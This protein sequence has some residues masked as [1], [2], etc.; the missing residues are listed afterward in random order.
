MNLLINKS[1]NN[2]Y[3]YIFFSLLG[4]LLI[5]IINF[6]SIKGITSD[7]VIQFQRI[8]WQLDSLIGFFSNNNLTSNRGDF[9][10]YIQK[11]PS[12]FYYKLVNPTDNIAGN[13]T[14][15]KASHVSIYVYTI[16]T[17][18]ILLFVSQKCKLKNFWLAPCFLLISPVF[19]GH[20]IFNIKDIPFAFFYTLF[21]LLLLLYFESNLENEKRRKYYLIIICSLLSSFKLTVLPIFIFQ[22]M[23]IQFLKDYKEN[24]P[25]EIPN[26]INSFLKISFQCCLIIIIMT[27]HAWINPFSYI[28]L[29]IYR[30]INYP[31]E[32]CS[33]FAG[34]CSSKYSLNG[35]RDFINI[36]Y[37]F[38]WFSI[39]FTILNIFQFLGSFFLFFRTCYCIFFQ[40]KISKKAIACFVFGLQLFLI[41]FIGIITNQGTYNGVRHFLF[42][43]PPNAFLGS[44]A[45]HY[46]ER[47]INYI[48]LK[49]VIG[50]FLIILLVIN[51]IDILSLSPYQY[52]YL[53]EL[54]RTKHLK[55]NTDLDYWG[56][57]LSKL[58]EKSKVKFNLDQDEE[59]IF[60]GY[61]YIRRF[62]LGSINNDYD[63]FWSYKQPLKVIKRIED[64]Y[65]IH[66]ECQYIKVERYYPIT[67]HKAELSFIYS[68]KKNKF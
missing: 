47:K 13:S 43:F 52:T 26:L 28:P 61:D 54:S 67:K 14:Y 49:K 44:Y 58:Y 5:S 63:I 20:S 29:S 56:A 4:I 33:E 22:I 2:F 21:S 34:I 59:N 16:L 7:E 41:P 48:L 37:L 40:N 12:F 68:C 10:G 9:Y 36:K 35:S 60:S 39:K 51:Y 17:S 65:N 8:N 42:I 6:D 1:V 50:L 18:I 55:R 3:K 23:I 15:Y 25:I 46:L 31:W 24:I 57:S 64:K 11:L 30:F 27:P 53:N 19:I 66:D 32:D 38:N 62:N 45:I